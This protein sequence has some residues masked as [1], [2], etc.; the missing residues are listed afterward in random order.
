M[1]SS[2]H[3]SLL[4][5]SQPVPVVVPLQEL[6]AGKKQ[7]K[8]KTEK[9]K[10][11]EFSDHQELQQKLSEEQELFAPLAEPTD[12]DFYRTVKKYFD[13]NTIII[14]KLSIIRK[15]SEL[16]ADIS[17]ASAVGPLAFYCRAKNKQRCSEGDLS[18]VFLEGQR[19]KLPVLFLI[20][21]EI[22]KKATTLLS[23]EFTTI[24][25]KNL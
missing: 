9:E 4:S 10:R 17:V 25:I 22:T 20:T 16:E 6:V 18:T 7:K 11:E 2:P 13:A 5:S 1:P 3:S 21:G 14:K 23:S 12:D 15:N 24:T 19:R 8:K